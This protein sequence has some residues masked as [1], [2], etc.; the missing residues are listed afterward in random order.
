MPQS[1]TTEIKSTSI[2]ARY[3]AV[4]AL[5]QKAVEAGQSYMIR[6]SKDGIHHLATVTTFPEGAD[7]DL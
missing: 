5:T 4:Y 6:L 1:D 3:V 2:N 7:C